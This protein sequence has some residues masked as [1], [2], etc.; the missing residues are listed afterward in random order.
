MKYYVAALYPVQLKV[1]SQLVSV[2]D[3]VFNTKPLKLA[4]TFVS[5]SIVTVVGLLVPLASPLQL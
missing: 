3:G 4:V 2:P 5:P 1:L